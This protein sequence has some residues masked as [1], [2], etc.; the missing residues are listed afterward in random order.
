MNL[1]IKQ[2]YMPSMPSKP[3]QVGIS[4]PKEIIHGSIPWSN[5]YVD[6]N[7]TID[8]IVNAMMVAKAMLYIF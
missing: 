2:D 7:M 8:S 4:P 5:A 6:E 3:H 1:G